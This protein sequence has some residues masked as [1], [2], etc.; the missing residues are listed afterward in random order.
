MCSIARISG[1]RSGLILYKRAGGT[2]RRLLPGG[3][4]SGFAVEPVPGAVF[5]QDGYV[6]FDP[7]TVQSVVF[8]RDDGLD[9]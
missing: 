5:N 9:V 3:A 7:S 2:V 6:G 4:D 1:V 8:F